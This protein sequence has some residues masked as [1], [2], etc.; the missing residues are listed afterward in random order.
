MWFP[1][2]VVAIDPKHVVGLRQQSAKIGQFAHGYH[3]NRDTLRTG[4]GQ[5]CLAK[6]IKL[7]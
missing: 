6:Q 5:N 3:R 4:D 7:L 2:G 1:L